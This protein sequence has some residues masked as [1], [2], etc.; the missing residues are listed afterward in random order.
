MRIWI[1]KEM[2]GRNKG[3]VTMFIE[4]SILGADECNEIQKL[5]EKY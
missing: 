5:I 3:I 2:E 1:G 4:T